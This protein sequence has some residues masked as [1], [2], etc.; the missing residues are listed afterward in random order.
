VV[1]VDR[2]D[3]S[4]SPSAVHVGAAQLGVLSSTPGARA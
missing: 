1:H 2:A 4:L 3:I